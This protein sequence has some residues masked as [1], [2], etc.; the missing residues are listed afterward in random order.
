VTK[1]A[2]EPKPQAPARYVEPAPELA[3]WGVLRGLRGDCDCQ[4]D[5]AGLTVNV[6]GTLHV[7]SPELKVFNADCRRG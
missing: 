4:V 6:P 5:A 3:T 7:L 1:F 2:P